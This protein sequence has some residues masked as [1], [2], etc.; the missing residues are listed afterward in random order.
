MTHL[1]RRLKALEKPFQKHHE[2]CTLED[3]CRTIWRQ[4]QEAFRKMAE[5][6]TYNFFI[7][8]FE[9]EEAERG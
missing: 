4:D 5:H 1:R 6:S 2:M 8:Q 3:L 9:Y 7:R